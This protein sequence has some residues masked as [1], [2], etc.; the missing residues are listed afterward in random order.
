MTHAR[1]A[2]RA[3]VVSVGKRVE[4]R[5]EMR[6]VGLG[7]RREGVQVGAR[8]QAADRAG[9]PFGVNAVGRPRLDVAERRDV[10]AAKDLLGIDVRRRRP[11]R[12]VDQRRRLAELRELVAAA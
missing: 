3:D 11:H 1:S 4:K 12:A 2:S 9:R 10:L 8:V 7:A 5:V 6:R